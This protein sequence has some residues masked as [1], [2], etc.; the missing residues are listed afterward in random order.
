VVLVVLVLFV[1]V[2]VVV[3]GHSGQPLQNQFSQ[4]AFH[5]PTVVAQTPGK[6]CPVVVVVVS[7]VVVL[8]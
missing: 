2:V 1:V 8:K 6:H 5:P 3:K 4:A 7:V